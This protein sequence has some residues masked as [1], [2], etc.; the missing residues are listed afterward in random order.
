MKD[1]PSP[2]ALSMRTVPPMATDQLIGQPQ[3]HAEPAVLAPDH[4]PLEALEDAGTVLLGDA[5]APV[6]D[7]KP[8]CGPSGAQSKA[9]GLAGAELQRV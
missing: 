7:R 3:P 4:G 8:R 1:A 2:G 9:D 6:P 5:Y